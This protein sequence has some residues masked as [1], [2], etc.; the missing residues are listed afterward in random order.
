MTPKELSR[1][2]AQSPR[3]SHRRLVAVAGP[4]ASGKSTL[5]QELAA[6]N[7]AWCVVPMDGF[8]LDNAVLDARGLADR[9]GA[10]QTFDAVGFRHLIARAAQPEE[11]VYPLFDRA[12]DLSVNC[13]A[14]LG[15]QIETVIVEGNYLLLSDPAWRDLHEKWDLSI[16]LEVSEPVLEQRLTARWEAHG[17][18]PQAARAKPLANDMPNAKL[19]LEQSIRADIAIS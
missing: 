17:L 1:A 12:G 2:I 9:K 6:A 14:V 5:A 4:P 11:V 3:R 8:H 16:M 7:P 15:P 19:V 18:S 13:A 10:P